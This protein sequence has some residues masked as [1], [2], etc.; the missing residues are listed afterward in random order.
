MPLNPDVL[1]FTHCHL[2][3]D[4]ISELNVFVKDLEEGHC[5]DEKC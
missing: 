5:L 3:R 4:C 1:E 2:V